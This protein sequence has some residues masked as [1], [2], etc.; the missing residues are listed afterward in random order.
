MRLR[1]ATISRAW[2]SMSD[3]VP[4]IPP[5]GW[6]MMIRA[7]GKANRFSLAPAAN[8]SAPILAACPIHIVETSG[9]TYCIVS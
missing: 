5:Q 8:S 4:C 3:A 6:W 2:I 7:F 9:S 1:M